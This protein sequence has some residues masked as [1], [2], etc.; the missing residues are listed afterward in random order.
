MEYFCS[1]FLFLF[2]LENNSIASRS[3]SNFVHKRLQIEK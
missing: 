3:S 2:F 1:N